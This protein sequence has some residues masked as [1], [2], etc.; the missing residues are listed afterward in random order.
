MQELMLS[1]FVP[2]PTGSVDDLSDDEFAQITPT[3]NQ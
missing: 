2:V 1:D 3:G